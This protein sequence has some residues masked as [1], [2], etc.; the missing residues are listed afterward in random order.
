MAKKS[1][2]NIVI[3]TNPYRFTDYNTDHPYITGPL[4]HFYKS[5]Q[6]ISKNAKKENVQKERQAGVSEIIG[7]SIYQQLL[8]HP[9]QE[10][11]LTHHNTLD[12][13]YVRSE[14]F[15]TNPSTL[16][17]FYEK[18]TEKLVSGPATMQKLQGF[19]QAIAAC[20]ILGETA[21]DDKTLKVSGNTISQT[22]FNG[23]FT[24]SSPTDFSSMA[25]VTSKN[26]S[27][28]RR[29][30][31]IAEGNLP[32]NIEKYSLALNKMLKDYDE[33][34]MNAVIAQRL[35]DL[36]KAGFDPKGLVYKDHKGQSV[37]I[38]SFDDLKKFYKGQ[39]KQNI[40]NMQEIAKSAEIVAKFS[41][42]PSGFKDIR[43]LEEFARTKFKDPV[44]YAAHHNIQ[45][46][47]KNA[48]DW[49]HDNDYKIKVTPAKGSAQNFTALE[50]IVH[51]KSAGRELS[52]AEEQFV[53]QANMAGLIK[54]EA[55]TD[56]ALY[57]KS[58]AASQEQ[59]AIGAIVNLVDN[60]VEEATTK[61][62]TEEQVTEFYDKLLN[63]LKKQGYLTDKE[64]ANIKKSDHYKDN[65]KETA[66]LMNKELEP[67][68]LKDRDA[69]YYK[70]ANFAKA[71]GLPD[72][73]SNYFMSQITPKK[74]TTLHA[75]EQAISK[76][77]Q[78]DN[79]VPES[80]VSTRKI[81]TTRLKQVNE[82][83]TERLEARRKN[84]SQS[85]VRNR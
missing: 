50:Y 61:K 28:L 72:G 25:A 59:A 29:Q 17:K 45:I 13:L 30:H 2:D 22:D 52:E 68:G 70:V 10:S 23:A 64:V 40:A 12:A 27:S 56:S 69:L 53:A 67:L 66:R 38:N 60:L 34:N 51:S 44:A 35:D 71:I 16:G 4:K 77:V 31:V 78:I 76:R 11:I 33:Q 1:T 54:H 48:L 43:W 81:Q 73:I 18:Q 47:G 46:E 84:Q 41:N 75:M 83:S 21:Y 58:K 37:S 42:A 5:E 62:L 7:F 39:A 20:H 79:I 15:A 19:E 14:F 8:G 3:S 55:K 80:V 32:F 63:N 9:T 85:A 24:G 82:S 57:A 65:A 36:Q 49:A 6:H 26:F 74:L